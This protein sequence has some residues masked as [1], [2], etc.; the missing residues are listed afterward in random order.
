MKKLFLLLFLGLIIAV[1]FAIAPANIANKNPDK[2]EKNDYIINKSAEEKNKGQGEPERVLEKENLKEQNKGDE[3]KIRNEVEN[4]VQLEKQEDAI[5]IKTENLT[6]K[7]NLKV[8]QERNENR[9]RLRLNLSN[10]RVFEI[11]IMP[12]VAAERAIE[13]LQLKVCSLENNCLIELKEVGQGNETRAVYKIEAKKRVKILGIFDAEMPVD[14]E[15]DA[16]NG[17]VLKTNVPWWAFLTT[18]A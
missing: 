18:N 2:N 4:E 17:E 8:E 11:K 6:V 14:A 13:R 3:N 7:T 15:V 1:S 10:N 12:N 16:E 9:T 5:L